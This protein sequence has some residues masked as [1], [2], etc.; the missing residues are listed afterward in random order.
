MR[1]PASL[2]G[3]YGIRTTHGRLD[4]AGTMD[5][6]PSFDTIGWFA[7]G[8]GVFRNVGAAL[9]GSG[10]VGAKIENLLIADDGFEQ[11]DPEVA[12]L[13]KS[14][15]ARMEGDLPKAQPVRIAPDGGFDPWREAVRLIQAYEIWQVYGL[16]L[17]HI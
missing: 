2:C 11:A 17:I 9:L 8:P 14:A 6:S 12:T 5:M 1:I 16:S 3:I 4:G 7:N 10:G 13:L 15:L